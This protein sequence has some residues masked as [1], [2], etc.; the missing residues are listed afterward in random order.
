V[1]FLYIFE[2][3]YNRLKISGCEIPASCGQFVLFCRFPK[4]KI[5]L[6]KLALKHELLEFNP[7]KENNLSR[8]IEIE[9]LKNS[10]I[11]NNFDFLPSDSVN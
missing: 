1:Y 6:V 7:F 4:L 3:F 5:I 2:C 9:L 8:P 10:E 11:Q